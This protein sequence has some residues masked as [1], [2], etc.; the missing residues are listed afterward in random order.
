MATSVRR[1]AS[2][3][4]SLDWFLGPHAEDPRLPVYEDLLLRTRQRGAVD[5]RSYALRAF[6][7]RQLSLLGLLQVD[8]ASE[9]RRE[10]LH[11]LGASRSR[12][13]CGAARSSGAGPSASVSVSDSSRGSV[14]VG[15]I[16]A[17]GAQAVARQSAMKRVMGGSLRTAV[18]HP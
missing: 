9:R 8:P 10:V 5:E 3:A 13:R 16:G 12:W 2:A 6:A 1:L 17:E 14:P 15:S 4:V 18:R 7:W 11:E